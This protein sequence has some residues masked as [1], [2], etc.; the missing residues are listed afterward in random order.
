MR[1]R[2]EG[3]V[4]PKWV[5]V[6]CQQ[7]PVRKFRWRRRLAGQRLVRQKPK[8]SFHNGWRNSLERCDTG[9]EQI[10]KRFTRERM[11]PNFKAAGLAW[12]LFSM[13]VVS[14]LAIVQAQ[15][16]H[17]TTV[18]HTV[19]LKTLVVATETKSDSVI[20]VPPVTSVRVSLM[21]EKKAAGA[22]AVDLPNW[23][24]KQAALN[25]LPSRD[26]L[27][28]HIVVTYDQF[29]EDGDNVH[30]GVYEEYWAAAKKI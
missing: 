16:G 4:V 15:E 3:S 8:D 6:G 11:M 5:A 29:D 25:G 7:R 2:K 17:P 30:S 12:V 22:D 9:K 1:L 26:L 21:T 24:S 20:A 14:S 19:D 10:R 27:P 23:L 13:L 18:D 28:W